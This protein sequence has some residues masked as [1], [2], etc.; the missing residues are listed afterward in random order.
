MFLSKTTKADLAFIGVSVTLQERLRQILANEGLKLVAH[1]PTQLE[2]L[3]ALIDAPAVFIEV[4]SMPAVDLVR[5]LAERRDHTQRLI[6]VVDDYR[7]QYT[8][9][10]V[11]LGVADL[12][13]PS[14]TEAELLAS[15]EGPRS[16]SGARRVLVF[17]P[18]LGGMGATTIAIE[19]AILLSR[20]GRSPT[21]LVDLDLYA[22]ECADFLNLTPRLDMDVLS[23]DESRID[24][25][26]LDLV[27]CEHSSRIRLLASQTRLGFTSEV[28]PKAILKLLDV[29]SSSFENVVI[30]F[31]RGWHAWSDDV[32]SGCDFIFLVTDSTIPALKAARRQLEEYH[33]RFEDRVNVKV[34]V[35]RTDNSIFRAMAGEDDFK[36]VFG[37]AF[38]GSII[39]E[40]KVARLAV[41]S[42]VP[43]SSVKQSSK[44]IKN[45]ASILNSL[46]NSDG[47]V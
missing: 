7:S 13:T 10:L 29:I 33:T 38:A 36:R 19:T 39:D 46:P 3:S 42:G 34:I 30:D 35:N 20:G 2:N 47:S 22:G 18:V 26:L 8:R 37:D 25:H 23:G 4:N 24:S 31:P 14:M 9:D 28:N 6:A 21:C 32:I 5:R 44:I 45:L 16:G 41:D 27:L 15:L 11:R 12:I 17:T 43:I 40:S 1:D